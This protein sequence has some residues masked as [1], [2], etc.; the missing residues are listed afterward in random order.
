MKRIEKAMTSN[1]AGTVLKNVSQDTL[2]GLVLSY[3]CS[4]DDS[5]LDKFNAIVNPIFDKIGNIQQQN[6]ELTALRNWL[7]PMLMNGQ[8]T[9]SADAAVS[10]RI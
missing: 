5:T 2:K 7:L 9:V 8:V 10:T 6:Q 1:A 3:P 4:Q